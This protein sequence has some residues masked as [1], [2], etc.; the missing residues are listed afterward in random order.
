[1][2]VEEAWMTTATSP[3]GPFRALK[4]S[5]TQGNGRSNSWASMIKRLMVL[6]PEVDEKLVDQ[7]TTSVGEK[8]QK[9]EG[10]G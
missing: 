2:M 10:T 6:P 7:W 1:M 8:R 9:R 4:L 3:A 5:E